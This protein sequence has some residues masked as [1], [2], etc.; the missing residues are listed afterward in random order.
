MATSTKHETYLKAF[1][2]RNCKKSWTSFEDFKK[3]VGTPLSK[4]SRLSRRCINKGFVPGNL[5]WSSVINHRSKYMITTIQGNVASLRS[6]CEQDGIKYSGPAAFMNCYPDMK[7]SPQE[8]YEFFRMEK[9]AR[10]AF[11]RNLFKHGIR[12]KLFT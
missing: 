8:V 6:A 12:Q 5:E 4:K 7:N 2:K 1:Y 10:R 9:T 11:K 3:E